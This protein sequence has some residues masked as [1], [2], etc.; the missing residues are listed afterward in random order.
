MDVRSR[1]FVPKRILRYR[2]GEKAAHFR[3]AIKR[4]GDHVA[5]SSCKDTF[6]LIY[7]PKMVCAICDSPIFVE[8]ITLP[9]CLSRAAV[10]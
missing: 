5:H 9:A 4:M 8:Y 10:L 1:F 6:F 7:L 3:Q 2:E